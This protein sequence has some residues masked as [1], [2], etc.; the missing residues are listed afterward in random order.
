MAGGS[1]GSIVTDRFNFAEKKWRS[2]PQLP[3]P[4]SEATS[5]N[6]LSK[7]GANSKITIV[8]KSINNKNVAFDIYIVNWSVKFADIEIPA[9]NQF[10]SFLKVSRDLLLNCDS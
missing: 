1:H 3:Q 6:H 9:E 10:V 5:Y 7:D 4:I 2:G 8:G